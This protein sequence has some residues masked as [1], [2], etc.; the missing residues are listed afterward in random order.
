MSHTIYHVHG[1]GEAALDGLRAEAERIREARKRLYIQPPKPLPEIEVPEQPEL[2]TIRGCG[3]KWIG[4]DVVLV[5]TDEAGRSSTG[6]VGR[7]ILESLR[8]EEI[9]ELTEQ[10]E[11]IAAELEAAADARR[12]E[13]ERIV[14]AA[15]Q[16]ADPAI[17]A[18]A[19]RLS[20]E[21]RADQEREAWIRAHGSRRLKRMLEEG[22]EHRATYRDERIAMERPDWR[23]KLDVPGRA[24]EPRNPPE[25]AFDLLDEARETAPD[26]R[27][28]YWL[29]ERDCEE[30]ESGYCTDHDDHYIR[31]YTCVASFLGLDIVFRIADDGTPPVPQGR[32]DD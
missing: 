7:Y 4:G 16:D 10:A 1:I 8:P 3:L 6:S 17:R 13:I 29:A 30:C 20:D 5:R 27:L 14:E 24:E 15:L 21:Q 23:Y 28:V 12:A 18:L 25:A 32:G 11:K 9:L 19:E 2:P 26:A 22:I 31:G